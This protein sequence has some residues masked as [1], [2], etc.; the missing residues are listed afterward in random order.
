MILV[1]L[2][3]PFQAIYPKPERCKNKKVPFCYIKV[4]LVFSF[5]CIVF[6][7]QLLPDNYYFS[8]E[9]VGNS[10][11]SQTPSFPDKFLKLLG[12]LKLPPF[13]QEYAPFFF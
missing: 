1:I 2:N 5:Y 8:L 4:L 9:D 10:E 6:D 3:T 11:T 12:K 7:D 13:S